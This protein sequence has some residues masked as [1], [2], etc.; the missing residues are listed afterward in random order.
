[1]TLLEWRIDFNKHQQYRLLDVGA[2]AANRDG[3]YTT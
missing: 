3:E 1:L 2:R